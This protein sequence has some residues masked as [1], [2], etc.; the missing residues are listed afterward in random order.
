VVEDSAAC[1]KTIQSPVYQQVLKTDGAGN[2]TWTNGANSTVLGKDSTGKVE[3]ATL[4]SVLQSGPV[5]LGIQP[6]TTTGAIN[7]GVITAMSVT[8]TGAVNAA[9][10][11]TTGIVTT[12]GE[13]VVN[14][15]DSI[16]E[17]GQ[18]M[19]MDGLL[20]VLVLQLHLI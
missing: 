13:I 7:S 2:L 15:L 1:Q 6:L 12:T 20:I 4:N 11:T 3:F 18:I 5:D 10:V 8:A 9:S 14:R 19:L 16:N 17:G